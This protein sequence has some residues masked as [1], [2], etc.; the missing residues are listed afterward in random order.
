MNK[1]AKAIGLSII[2]GFALGVI[3]YFIAQDGF[4]WEKSYADLETRK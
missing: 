3:A 1:A 4:V 2:A